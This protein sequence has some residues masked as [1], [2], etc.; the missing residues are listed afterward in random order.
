MA[1]FEFADD[2]QDLTPAELRQAMQDRE[3]MLADVKKR[4]EE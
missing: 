3:T 4:N 1:E 2:S